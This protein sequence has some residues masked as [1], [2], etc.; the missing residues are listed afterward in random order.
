MAFKNVSL[1]A[2]LLSI[3]IVLTVLPLLIVAALVYYENGRMRQVAA[4]ESTKL[5]S[6]DLDH[7]A[8]GVYSMC[9]LQQQ[10]LEQK[11][12]SDLAVARAY[13]KRRGDVTL[14][15]ADTVEWQATNQFTKQTQTVDL[16]K[17]RVGEEWLGKNTSTTEPS[18]VVDDVRE[19][20]GGTATIFQRMNERGDM[21]RVCTNVEKTDGSRAIGTYIPAANPDG[22]PNPVV[23][24]VLS[25]STFVGRAYV[26]NQWYITAYEPIRDGHGEVIGVLY[27]GVPQESVAV[28]REQVMDIQVGQTGYVYVLDSNGDYVISKNGT[29]DGERIWE[30]RDA[31]GNLFIQDVVAQATALRPGE[32]GEIRY[33]WKNEGDAESRMKIVRLMY[34]EPWDWIIGAGSYVDEFYAAEQQVAAIGREANM[35]LLIV[36]GSALVAACGIWFVIA[37]GLAGRIMGIVRQLREGS[38]QVAGA[39]DQVS[40]SSQSLAQGATEQASSLEEITASIEEMASQTKQNS[41]SA[42]EAKTLADAAR[43]NADKGAEA[44]RRMSG[45]IDDIKQ[46]SDETAKI[47]STIDEIAFQTNLLALNAAVEA[48]RAGEAGKGFAVVAEEVRNLAQRSAEA[49]RNTAEMIEGSVKNADNGVSIGKEVGDVLAQI[50]DGNR[51]VSELVAEISA[52]SNEQSQGIDQVSTAVGQLDQV[53]QSSAA[54]AEES[55]SSAEELSAQAEEMHRIVQQ[56]RNVV[57]GSNDGDDAG[58]EHL[59]NHRNSKPTKT[60]KPEEHMP[61]GIKSGKRL[62]ALRGGHKQPQRQPEEVIPMDEEELASF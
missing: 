20:V 3:G 37:R 35:L 60:Q 26:V 49:A 55:A 1:K 47:I 31:D 58:A 54:N 7:I 48:A 59:G 41:A 12:R 42:G 18:P 50:V 6:A 11:V 15:E 19:A 32:I 22:A 52:A 10:L 5:A 43:E 28:L 57:G 40:S 29:R 4:E 9:N 30:A 53:T 2:K 36:S 8:E 45:A 34:F 33:P 25:G 61:G 56:L 46:S 17:M 38:V 21:L 24:T 14:D 39:S 62:Q 51:K 44:M 16:P 27:V 23:S 13:M